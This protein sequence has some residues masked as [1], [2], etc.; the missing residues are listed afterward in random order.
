MS[1]HTIMA[2]AAVIAARSERDRHD[3]AVVLGSGLGDHARTLP[4]AVELPYESIA[5]FPVPQ[6]PGHGGSLFSVPVADGCVLV[7]AGRAHSYEG[8][9]MDDVVFGVRTAVASGAR[10]VLI[11]NAAGGVNDAYAPGDLVIIRDHLNLTGRNPL[12]GPNDDRLGPR[13]PDMSDVYTASL[14]TKLAGVFAAQ[15]LPRHE[16]V[17]AWFPGPT[18]ETPAEVQMAKRLGADLVGMSTVPEAIAVSHM[19]A[20]VAGI[21]LVTNLA[22]GIGD[23]PLSHDDVTETASRARTTFASVL[24]A[25]LP[26]LVE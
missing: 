8:H 21:S 23:G 16:G 18:Y 14:R 3:A 15:G 24:D 17:Y 6:V 4:G 2:A 9:P 11:T 5:G 25:F 7:F 13:F 12:T 1:Y 10:R 26:I 20:E 19:G 22:A